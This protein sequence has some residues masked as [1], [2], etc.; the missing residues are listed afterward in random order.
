VG[1]PA[2]FSYEYFVR[3][4]LSAGRVPQ[5]GVVVSKEDVVCRIAR[6]TLMYP[7][8]SEAGGK[9]LWDRAQRILQNVEHICRLPELA[10]QAISIDRFCLVAAGYFSDAGLTCLPDKQKTSQ[11]G[12]GIDAI[13][14]DGCHLSVQ[15]VSEKLAGAVTENRIDTINTI[16]SESFNRLTDLTE[17]MI[18][19]DARGLEDLGTAGL[20]SIFRR[21]FM[22][23]K[24]ISDILKSWK[25]K[26]EYGYWHARLAEGFRFD[27]VRQVAEQR[28]AAAE[29]FM[30]RL[31]IENT[32][33][34]LS[35][36]LLQAAH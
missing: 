22:D 10:E 6:K 29:E 25:R 24:G 13:N 35:E 23:G 17:A 5:K 34:D 8:S 7:S 33:G 11:Q 16:I 18:L 20:L 3:W 1:A 15:I 4:K 26:I 27:A 28:F 36:R 14:A 32:A 2:L 30:H 9:W 31:A 21:Q 12:A 19:S